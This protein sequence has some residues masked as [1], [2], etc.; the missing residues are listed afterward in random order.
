VVRRL[1]IFAPILALA[2][3]AA[4]QAP[5]IG[6]IE[7]Y[8]LQ[9][10]TPAKLLAVLELKPGA[11]LPASKGE[12]EERLEQIPG[13]VAARV[14]A[15][16]CDASS[17][18][19]FIGIEE[20]GAPHF[21][22]RSAPAGSAVLPEDLMN[23]Y[24]EFL[25]A[26]ERAAQS[27]RAAE[28]LTSGEARLADPAASR[29]Q[30]H[31]AGFAATNLSLLREVL[32]T[33]PEPEER[34]VAAAVIGYAPHKS[35]IVND[36]QYG[37]QDPEPAVRANAA[38]ALQAI[39]VLAQKR[40]DLNLRVEPAWLV[41]MLN[42]LVLSD[43]LQAL[44]TLVTLTDGTLTNAAPTEAHNAATLE[45]IRTRALPAL[46][47]MARW[48]SLRHALPAFLL[49]GRATGASESE[50]LAQWKAGDRETAIRQATAPA[51]KARARK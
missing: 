41:E 16:C 37:L 43:R 13:I 5:K 32:R 49:M 34:A 36:L 24:R 23:S 17:A 11:P 38:R 44:Q 26:V 9:K 7:F 29:L 20:P 47:E 46:V 40:P 1:G 14:E 19:L 4:A 27:G 35:E 25:T 3:S 15:I 31:L 18:T 33:G 21:N 50:L 6:E 39:A 28:D 8:G 48:K 42:S 12:L 30:D 22:T 45:L 2:L 10:L 51:P